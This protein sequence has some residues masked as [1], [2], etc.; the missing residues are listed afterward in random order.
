M[1]GSGGNT[2]KPTESEK[3]LTKVASERW[4]DYQTRFKP[5]EKDLIK[6]TEA[7]GFK[8]D[9]AAGVAN[10]DVQIAAGGL[11]PTSNPV[12]IASRNNA[13]AGASGIAQA[14]GSQAVDNVDQAGKL[15]MAAFGEGLADNS[16]LGTANAT[17][18][19]TSKA[20]SDAK[21]D[22][23]IKQGLSQG[24]G[25]VAGAYTRKNMPRRETP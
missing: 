12:A 19:A 20:I 3:A 7:T 16:V 13:V 2:P 21:Y 24:L 17:R 25:I 9:Q 1:S 4:D 22:Y 15:K 14:G 6:K 10:A 23:S 5:L 11:N 8:R 18:R